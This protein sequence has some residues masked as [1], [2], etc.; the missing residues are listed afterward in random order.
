MYTH[1]CQTRW[2]SYRSH[3]PSSRRTELRRP[4]LRARPARR[5]TGRP[6]PH[7]SRGA[8][9]TGEALDAVEIIDPGS[10]T[11]I[12]LLPRPYSWITGSLTPSESTRSRIVSMACCTVFFECR[13]DGGLHRQRHVCPIH[14]EVVFRRI[15]GIQGGTDRRSVRRRQP[16]MRMTSFAGSGLYTW[17]R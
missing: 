12:S 6:P 15:P 2:P 13:L 14:G 7:G 17:V 5:C 1:R 9:W 16:S 4:R 11:A 8:P 10:S 3:A